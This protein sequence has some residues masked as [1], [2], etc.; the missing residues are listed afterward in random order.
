MRCHLFG[1][2]HKQHSFTYGM[3]LSSWLFSCPGKNEGTVLTDDTVLRNNTEDSHV[4]FF[5]FSPHQ[6]NMKFLLVPKN[7]EYL[8]CTVVNSELIVKEIKLFV[9]LQQEHGTRDP[10]GAL[11]PPQTLQC[12]TQSELSVQ[13]LKQFNLF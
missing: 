12:F 10:I 4:I 13:N 1:R 8:G 5:L 11:E 3:P 6:Q 9:L 7:S 2:R